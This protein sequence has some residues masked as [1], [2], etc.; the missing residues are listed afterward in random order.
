MDPVPDVPLDPSQI[1]DELT[2]EQIV[3]LAQSFLILT[4]YV[5]TQA[6]KCQ[7]E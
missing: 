5:E 7:V 6:K 2:T 1:G 3:K 4:N